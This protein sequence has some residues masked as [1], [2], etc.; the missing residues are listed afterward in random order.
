MELTDAIVW[1]VVVVISMACE[2]V[3]LVAIIGLLPIRPRG[4]FMPPVLPD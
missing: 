1:A 3:G 4:V 2:A